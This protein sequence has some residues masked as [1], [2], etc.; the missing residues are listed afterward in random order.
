MESTGILT[1]SG[2][3]ANDTTL[4]AGSGGSISITAAAVHQYGIIEAVGG[5]ATSAEDDAGAAG[6]GGRVTISV[7]LHAS[8]FSD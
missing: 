8:H 7:S 5:D 6:G 1:A 3:R 4:G 2:S